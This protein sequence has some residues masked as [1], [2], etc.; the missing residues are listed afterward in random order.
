M[1]ALDKFE[2]LI[3]N[4]QFLVIFIHTL[5]AQPTFTMQD[6][7]QLASLLML[8][9]QHKMDYATLYVLHVYY[10]HSSSCCRKV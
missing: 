8:A 5:E 4:K 1:Q 7:V 6:K 10:S 3:Y 9:L 2:H